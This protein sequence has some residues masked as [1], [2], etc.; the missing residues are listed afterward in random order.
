MVI[1]EIIILIRVLL[2]GIIM[3]QGIQVAPFIV[4]YIVKRMFGSIDAR[5]AALDRAPESLPESLPGFPRVPPG[6]PCI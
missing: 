1:L 2:M 5:I 4:T 6:S 3:E